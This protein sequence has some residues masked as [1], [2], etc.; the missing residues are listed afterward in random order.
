MDWKMCSDV[1]VSC[2]QSVTGRV[3]ITKQPIGG[4]VR[5]NLFGCQT[6]RI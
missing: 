1:G 5:P 3:R 2:G 6:C 4:F